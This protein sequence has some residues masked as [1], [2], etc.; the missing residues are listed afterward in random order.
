LLL[1][2][3]YSA[4]NKFVPNPTKT[5]AERRLGAL[6]YFGSSEASAASVSASR[7]ERLTL[8]SD[9]NRSFLNDVVSTVDSRRNLKVSCSEIEKADPTWLITFYIIGVLY[10]FLAIAIA[11][12]EFF[13]PALEEMAS[14]RRLNLS[15]DVAGATLMAA[16]GSA[17]ELFTSLFGTFT[18]SEIG[19]G[20]IVGSAVFNVLFVIGVCSLLAKEILKLTWWPLFRDSLYYSVSLVVL[21]IF[22]GVAS[23]EKIFL[24]EACVLFLMYLVYVVIMY[25]NR[26]LYR[27]LTGKELEIDVEVFEEDEGEGNGPKDEGDIEDLRQQE[28]PRLNSMRSVRSADSFVLTVDHAHG[29]SINFRWHGTFRAGILKLLRD[30]DSWLD[31]AGVGIVAR[32][33]GD[34]DHVFR[35]VDINGDGSIDRDEL[36]NLFDLLECHLT[37]HE[38]D[39]VFKQLDEDGDGTVSSLAWCCLP[40]LRLFADIRNSANVYSDQRTRIQQVVCAVRGTHPFSG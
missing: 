18:E 23:P 2:L 36:E 35:R 40:A 12:D 28:R 10:M 31:T 13:V 3:G 25:F 5:R 21:A 27:M 37:P 20:T 11:C 14:E 30:P 1:V 38:L 29:K 6:S 17:P 22:I 32:I 19:F 24:W 26:D 33:A 7:Y 8:M 4:F 34:V 16:G 9:H 39:E 15:M